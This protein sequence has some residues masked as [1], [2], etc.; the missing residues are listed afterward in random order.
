MNFLAH[1]FLSYENEDLIIGNLI[2]DFISNKQV[3]NFSQ[4][5]QR[6]IQLHRNIDTFTDKHKVV[7]K[8]TKRLQATHHKYAPVVI[9]IFYDYLLTMNWDKYSDLSFPLFRKKI[10]EILERRMEE[11]PPKLKKYLPNMI[12]RDWLLSYSTKEGMEFT[13]DRVKKRTSFPSSLEKATENLFKDLNLYNEEFNQF[14][15]EVILYVK[16]LCDCKE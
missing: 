10:Y 1:L 5:V 7:R 14:F 8:G 4:E 2:A 12:E 3:P 16:S 6:G 15:P 13:F 9:D 11:M